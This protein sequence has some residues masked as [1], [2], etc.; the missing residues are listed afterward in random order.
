M[1]LIT[2]CALFY[3]YTGVKGLSV[4]YQVSQTRQGQASWWSWAAA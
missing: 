3:L 4:S 2:A 1:G